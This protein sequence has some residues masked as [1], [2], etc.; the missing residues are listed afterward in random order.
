MNIYSGF[1]YGLRDCCYLNISIFFFQVQLIFN[2]HSF[3]CTFV[4]LNSILKLRSGLFFIY[5]SN[6]SILLQ[7]IYG[8]NFEILEYLFSIIYFVSIYEEILSLRINTRRISLTHYFYLDDIIWEFGSCSL[9]RF[10]HH[11]KRSK[12][13]NWPWNHLDFTWYNF[14][15][16]VYWIGVSKFLYWCCVCPWRFYILN[17]IL[18]EH[19]LFSNNCNL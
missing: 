3:G 9:N 16:I 8:W 13:P 19:T 17:I 1:Y 10:Q 12:W 18:A 4:G 14:V 11:W 6:I 2:A 15:N 5:F 7:D